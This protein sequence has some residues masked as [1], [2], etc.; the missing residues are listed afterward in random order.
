MINETLKTLGIGTMSIASIQTTPAII[1]TIITP[2]TMHEAN[3]IQLMVQ[4]IVGLATIFKLFQKNKK[5]KLES[6]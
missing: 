6:E 2:D 5:T 1:D 3:L 4:V